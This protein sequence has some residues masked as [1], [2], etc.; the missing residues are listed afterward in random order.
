[1]SHGKHCNQVMKQD[2]AEWLKGSE[3]LL[4]KNHLKD[5]PS[6][7]TTELYSSETPSLWTGQYMSDNME[8]RVLYNLHFRQTCVQDEPQSHISNL[9]AT[10][11]RKRGARNG[12][13]RDQDRRSQNWLEKPNMASI[14]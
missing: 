4:P 12:L 9:L 14:G 5:I 11:P 8:A 7:N 3:L 2:Y 1:M 13:S 10:G 6:K